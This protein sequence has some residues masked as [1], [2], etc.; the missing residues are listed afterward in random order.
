MNNIELL[1]NILNGNS[2]DD[3]PS[4]DSSKWHPYEDYF[5][6][7][8]KHQKKYRI[9]E[10]LSKQ[11]H[12]FSNIYKQSIENVDNKGKIKIN[13][14][15]KDNIATIYLLQDKESDYKYIG[16]TTYSLV[17]FIK[18]NMHNLNIG[19]NN[20]F[21]NFG[22]DFNSDLLNC[23]FRVLEYVKYNTRFNVNSRCE[24][25]KDEYFGNSS[26]ALSGTPDNDL[27][28]FTKK[29]IFLSGRMRCSAE[30]HVKIENCVVEKMLQSRMDVFFEALGKYSSIFSPFKGYIYEIHNKKNNKKFIGGYREQ[31]L[32]KEIL[33]LIIQKTDNSRIKNDICRYGRRVFDVKLMEEYSAKTPFDFMLRID[34][35]KTRDD[36]IDGGYNMDYCLEESQDLFKKRLTTSKKDQITRSF[37]L[38][39]QKLI[40][41]RDFKDQLDYTD[42]YGYT[43]QIKNKKNGKRYIAYT[44]GKTLKQVIK[45]LY[46]DAGKGNI[47]HNKILIALSEEPFEDFHFKIKKIKTYN[48][49][50][51]DLHDEAEKLVQ[52]YNTIRDGYNFDHNKLKKNI[53][54]SKYYN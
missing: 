31:L 40:F 47:K 5:I 49:Y 2:H 29:E 4:I 50:K 18:L 1:N 45:K 28:K 37:F 3:R 53:L 41:S 38:K 22:F 35:L 27:D 19:E 8:N 16:Y 11:M 52:K 17:D 12:D 48:D 34:Y 32:K 39:I 14:N 42:I 25:Y 20:V 13:N 6:I 30:S 36:T 9:T 23:E 21:D 51:T 7:T 10:S 26:D 24:V 46:N 43:Y 15:N 44:H 54:M 33:D